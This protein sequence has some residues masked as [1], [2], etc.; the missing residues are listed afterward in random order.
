M[1]LA[2]RI[3]RCGRSML[4]S[5]PLASESGQA[6]LEL[7]FVLP[8][9]LVFLLVLVDFGLALDRRE[10][11]QHAARE[12]AR[13]GAVHPGVNAIIDET[14]KQSQEVLDASNVSVCYEDGPNGQTAGNAGSYVRVSIDYTYGF[15]AGSGELLTGFGLGTPSI[16]MTPA[17]EEVLEQPVSGVTVC[18]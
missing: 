15:T 14:V 8:I 17:A 13:Y 5:G 3:G 2:R 18:P 12:G 9:M 4:R 7:A 10:V 11:I 6:L 16:N 1:L